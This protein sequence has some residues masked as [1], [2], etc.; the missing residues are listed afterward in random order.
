MPGRD[1]DPDATTVEPRTGCFTPAMRRTA[2]TALA[3]PTQD[4]PS[5]YANHLFDPQSKRV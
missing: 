5:K 1:Q 3:A 2:T 4:D